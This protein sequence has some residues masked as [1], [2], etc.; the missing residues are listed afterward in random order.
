[1][2]ISPINL[3]AELIQS[4]LCRKIR[5]TFLR[6]LPQWFLKHLMQTYLN[7]I[8][9]EEAPAKSGKTYQNQNPADTREIV[10]E[11]P[12]SGRED[13]REAV[14]AAQKSFP[15][16][17]AMTPVA[18]GRIL[19]KTS[20]VLESRKPQLAEALTR[21]EGKT[22]VESQ[23]E[24][25]R[26]I[27]IFRFFGDGLLEGLEEP[28]QLALAGAHDLLDRGFARGRARFHFKFL[29]RHFDIGRH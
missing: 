12:L 24:V 16:W 23:G 22:L 3:P 19:S 9:G 20:Q 26:A 29:S 8:G 1:M 2:Q 14:Q 15:T 25:Q 10:T 21:E 7:F 6:D 4:G 13:A 27:D 28:V 11:Y 5:E 17:S 18:R